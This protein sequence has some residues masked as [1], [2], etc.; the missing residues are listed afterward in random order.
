MTKNDWAHRLS[1]RVPLFIHLLLKQHLWNAP[2]LLITQ[3][4]VILFYRLYDRIDK[5]FSKK[6]KYL[7]ENF[8]QV[9]TN[10]LRSSH[11][12]ADGHCYSFRLR[13]DHILIRVLV[14]WFHASQNKIKLCLG[15]QQ[16]FQLTLNV[17]IKV[18]KRQRS[19]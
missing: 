9:F 14:S 18:L 6:R 8:F 2:Y 1:G 13:C 10:C 4:L 7:M 5:S 15:F 12:L 16:L 11:Y 3:L 17:T 19:K